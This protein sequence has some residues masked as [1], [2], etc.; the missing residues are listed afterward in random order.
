MNQKSEIPVKNLWPQLWPF[1]A[2]YKSKMCWAAVMSVLSGC[3]VAAQPLLVK[4]II[5][6]GIIRSDATPSERMAYT[7]FYV[8]LYFFASVI[9]ILFWGFGMHN[10]VQAVEGVLFSIR[11]KFFRHVQGLVHEVPLTGIQWRT[12]Q[13]HHGVSDSLFKNVFV[14]FYYVSTN[15]YRIFCY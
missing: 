5:D 4:F 12:V 10:S 8:G 6:D 1:A 2:D 9:R 11:A 14:F 15:Q 3:G 13:L 7:L